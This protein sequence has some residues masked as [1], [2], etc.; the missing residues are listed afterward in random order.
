MSNVFVLTQGTILQA[1]P[2]SSKTTC[3]IIFTYKPY[4]FDLDSIHII[5]LVM[6][7]GNTFAALNVLTVQD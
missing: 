2:E 6:F 3:Q 7:A 5:I 4:N 1:C